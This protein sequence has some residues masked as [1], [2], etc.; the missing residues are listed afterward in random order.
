MT[1]ARQTFLLPLPWLALSLAAT[2]QAFTYAISLG[3]ALLAAYLLIA[4]VQRHKRFD[5]WDGLLV[6]WLLLLP[7]TQYL[8]RSPSQGALLFWSLTLF[9]LVFLAARRLPAASLNWPGLRLMLWLAAALLAAWGLLED[10]TYQY[11]DKI[12]GP[13]S[14]PNLYAASLNL[15]WLPLAAWFLSGDVQR[16]ALRLAALLPCWCWVPWRWRSSWPPRAGRRLPPC[17]CSR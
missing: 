14:D 6:A 8:S 13:F 16:P 5:R 3:A 2:L 17:C 7:I 4:A 12:D 10:P 9:P 1:T 15:F 11:A